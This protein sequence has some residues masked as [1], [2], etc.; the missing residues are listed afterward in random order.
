MPNQITLTVSTGTPPY[1]IFVCDVTNTY[2]YPAATFGGGTI[3][4]DSPYPLEYTTPILIKIVDTV[5]AMETKI[6]TA[7]KTSNNV[8]PAPLLGM[9]FF[10]YKNGVC[11]ILLLF[12]IKDSTPKSGAG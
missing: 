5:E 11:I 7:T 2:C 3:T 1:N 6:A 9:Y 10:L 8:N 4:F 12:F